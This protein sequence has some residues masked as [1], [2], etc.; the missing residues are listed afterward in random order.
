MALLL[1]WRVWVA[2][3]FVAFEAFAGYHV[4]KM[5]GDSVQVAFD[6]YKN[7]QEARTIAAEQQARAKEQALVQANQKV[8]TD[9]EKLKASSDAAVR[10][11]DAERVRLLATIAGNRSAAT[12]NTGSGLRSDATPED[13]V[14]ARCVGRR[15][16]VAEDAQS[17]AEQVIGLQSYI[18]TVCLGANK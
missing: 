7:Q 17:L 5:G 10:A 6:A 8:S 9:Y 12:P 15:T 1:N 14:L 11:L 4:Y 13:L 16:D 18:N 2:L 3:A